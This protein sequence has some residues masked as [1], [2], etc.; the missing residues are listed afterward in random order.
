M[1]L[2]I[3]ISLLVLTKVITEEEATKLTKGLPGSGI[4]V[5]SYKD[6]IKQSESILGRKMINL[7]K[8]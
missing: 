2:H 7:K 5:K 1:N 4:W 6:V 3:Y 8:I